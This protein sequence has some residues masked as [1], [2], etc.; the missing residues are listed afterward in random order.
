MCNSH[1]MMTAFSEVDLQPVI[2]EREHYGRWL[3]STG[4]PESTLHGPCPRLTLRYVGGALGDT[5]A[6]LAT[7]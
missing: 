3:D 1:K 4:D 7:S 2:L 6:H 5:R